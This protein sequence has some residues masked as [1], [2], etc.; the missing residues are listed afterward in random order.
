[1]VRM[2]TTPAWGQRRQLERKYHC[3]RFH[4][5]LWQWGRRN[6]SKERHWYRLYLNEIRFAI[7]LPWISKDA[8]LPVDLWAICHVIC[9]EKKTW[10]LEKRVGSCR[11][12]T[13][14]SS[15]LFWSWHLLSL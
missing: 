12:A 10:K 6:S 9:N 8:V 11:N 3:R 2:G 14:S 4:L 13:S 7:H 5:P 15:F 1:M